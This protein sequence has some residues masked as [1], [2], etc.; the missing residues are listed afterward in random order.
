M[1][2]LL[3]QL[4]SVPGRP[5]EN[6][7]RVADALAGHPYT[8]L[9]VFPELFLSGYPVGGAEPL[10]LDLEGSEIAA[11]REAASAHSTAV[12]VGFP[13]RRTDGVANA[14]A[15]VDRDGTLAAVYRKTHLFGSE[16]EAFVPG[17]ALVVTTLAGRR[18]GALVCFDIE[19]PEPAR[20]L[21]GAGADLLV[22]V[23]ANMAPY[24]ADHELA[25]RARAL[26]N[27]LPHVYSNAV[28]RADGLE[29]VGGS[30]SIASDGSV[31]A[32]LPHA[33]EELLVVPVADVDRSDGRVEYLSQL[34]PSLPVMTS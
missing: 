33:R 9:A 14:A 21:A 11:V 25:T 15:C 17:D 28:G 8:E 1:L 22:T 23:S 19:F 26:E 7:G 18:V 29:F 6:V 4:S 12:V 10:A 3:A 16:R 13:E 30:R 34:R 2:A 24:Y 32:E 5:L 27:R 20:A 31:L